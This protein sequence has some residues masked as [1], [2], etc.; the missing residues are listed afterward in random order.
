MPTQ[1]QKM[2]EVYAAGNENE[3]ALAQWMMKLGLNIDN[4]V[5]KV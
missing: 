2:Y 1:N 5:G 3:R 4:K